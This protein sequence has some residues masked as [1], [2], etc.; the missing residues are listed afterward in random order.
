[1]LTYSCL[2]VYSLMPRNVQISKFLRKLKHF[3]KI[4]TAFP[5]RKSYS[6]IRMIRPT[7]WDGSTKTDEAIS[8]T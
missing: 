8:G 2:P 3:L 7:V 6:V 5:E 4:F 1:M